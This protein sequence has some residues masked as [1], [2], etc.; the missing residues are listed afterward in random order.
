MSSDAFEK[1]IQVFTDP[2]TCRGNPRNIYTFLAEDL[3]NDP[4]K[5]NRICKAFK[6]ADAE[7]DM[8]DDLESAVICRVGSKQVM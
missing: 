1:L 5:K 8:N 6:I 3:R 2:S 7:R 4:D